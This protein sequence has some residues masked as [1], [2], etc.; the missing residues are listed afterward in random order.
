MQIDL[1]RLREQVDTIAVREGNEKWGRVSC[2][3]S[4]RFWSMF[5]SWE[6]RREGEAGSDCLLTMQRVHIAHPNS[7]LFAAFVVKWAV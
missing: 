6:E 7:S 1:A 4:G 3:F 2:Y 5:S